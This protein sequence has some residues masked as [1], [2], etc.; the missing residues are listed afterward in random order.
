M[1]VT[2]NTCFR[3]VT[4]LT[5]FSC[6]LK[7]HSALSSSAAE[8]ARK[9]RVTRKP[10]SSFSAEVPL[11]DVGAHSARHLRQL[12]FQGLGLIPSLFSSQGFTDKVCMLHCT[13]EPRATKQMALWGNL[14]SEINFYLKSSACH[15]WRARRRQPTEVG[16]QK[17][18]RKWM[19]FSID[20]GLQ[21]LKQPSNHPAAFLEKSSKTFGR[22][23]RN[24]VAL[25]IPCS[26][27][28]RPCNHS[29][30]PWAVKVTLGLWR[31]G[32]WGFT[33]PGRSNRV[34]TAAWKYPGK[35]REYL[36]LRKETDLPQPSG[37]KWLLL[38]VLGI[39]LEIG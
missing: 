1:D 27:H 14:A 16:R 9:P 36:A 18:K 24:S 8:S 19:G 34:K 23:R 32:V 22:Q 30:D 3:G 31:P 5:R 26:R 13:H 11:F 10:V 38:N 20:M 6:S 25:A 7:Y 4:V 35:F 39:H 37:L 28:F 29:V 15:H 17:L 2:S 33:G 21:A 12:K